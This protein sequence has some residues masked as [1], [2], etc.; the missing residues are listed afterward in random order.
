VRRRQSVLVAM[1]VAVMALSAC[2]PAVTAAP[3]RRSGKAAAQKLPA[4]S[5]PT[6]LD[7]REIGVSLYGSILEWPRTTLERDLDRVKAM[8]ATWVRVPLNWVTIEMHGKGRLEWARPDVVVQEA[9]ERGLRVLGVV[10]YTPQWA[11]PAGRPGTDPPTNLDDYAR[12]VGALAQR[13]GPRGVHH[14]EIWNEPNIDATWTPKPDPARYTAMLKKAHSAIKRADR[15]AV[16]LTAGMSPAW[17]APDGSQIAPATFISKVYANGGRKAFDAVAHHPSTFPHRSTYAA[18]WSAFQ[19]TPDMYAVMR[20]NGDRTKRIWASEIGF[21]TGRSSAAVSDQSQAKYLVESL[22]S[23][24]G[25]KFSGPVFVYSLRDEGADK[26]DHFQNFGL[27]RTDGTPKPAYT[28]IRRA[29][30]G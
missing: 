11:R 25:F 23:W 19:Q 9:N 3:G 8:G 20:A 27:L 4:A 6:V 5:K 13:Y 30:R 16:V 21:P 29:L 28:A 2:M 1:L 7:G 12:F 10:S 18:S 14:W 15:R 26:W 17:N 22:R 24:T